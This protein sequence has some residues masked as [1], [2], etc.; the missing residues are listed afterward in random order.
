MF[1]IL[2]LFAF[3]LNGCA[4]AVPIVASVAGTGF[5]YTTSQSA[6]RT[7]TEDFDTIK[8]A[9]LD[10]M[11]KMN[12]VVDNILYYG[13]EIEIE[14]RTDLMD[15]TLEIEPVT[16]KTT[17]VTAKVSKDIVRRDKATAIEI[18]DQL[19]EALKNKEN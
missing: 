10:A 6:S 9:S 5:V 18:L 8:N 13:R 1:L 19:K 11:E 16:S 12:I 15:V 2:L 7:Y 4:A 14:A 17:K 3:L